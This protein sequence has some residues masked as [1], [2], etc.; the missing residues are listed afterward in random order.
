MH[1]GLTGKQ[2]I[3]L[4]SDCCLSYLTFRQSFVSDYWIAFPT[5][6][7]W[8]VLHEG[9]KKVYY[10]YRLYC[11]FSLHGE[12]TYLLVGINL[13]HVLLFKSYYR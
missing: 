7:P 8:V 10:S 13:V 1:V 11:Q 3:L 12:L 5:H 9:G 6:T 4:V 2:N